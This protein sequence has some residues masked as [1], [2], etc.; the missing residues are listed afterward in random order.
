MNGPYTLGAL[1]D[2]C[3]LSVPAYQR[4][5]AWDEAQLTNF[6][7]DLR[8]HPETQPSKKYFFGTILLA[9][10]AE[11][12]SSELASYD[13]VDGQQ[14]LTTTCLFVSAAI[15][16]L[17]R[18]NGK[19]SLPSAVYED[20][21]LRSN[22]TRKFCTITEDD[23][24]FER[25]IASKE[26][27]ECSTPSQRRLLSA[28]QYF[29]R[30]LAESSAAQ[31]NTLLEKLN[32]AFILVYSVATNAEATQIFELQND[33]GKRLTNLEA[34]KSYLMHGIYV[35]AGASA[36]T[37][38]RIVQT[39]FAGIYRDIEKMEAQLDAPDEDRLLSYH[40]LAYETWVTLPGEVEGWRKPKELIKRLLEHVRFEERASWI[41]E[42]TY[43]L[44]QSYV[45]AVQILESRNRRC[46]IALGDLHV[47]GRTA[48][49]WPLFL[50]CWKFD[51]S[52]EKVQFAASVR[53]M[54]KFACR[55]IV[56]GKRSDAGES[57]LRQQARNFKGD[58]QSL[59]AALN[60]LRSWWEI[61]EM[62]KLKLNS[63]TFY[64]F[65]RVATYI[66]WRYEN[67]LREQ[68]GRQTGRL[69]WDTVAHPA[70]QAV[71]YAK[72]HIEPQ[73]PKNPNLKQLVKWSET[74]V[75]PRPFSEIYLNRLGNLVLDTVSTGASKGNA[76]FTRRIPKYTA[77]SVFLSQG[78]IVTRF[79]SIGENNER[80]WD[81][82]A[83]KR[84]HLALIEFATT[85]L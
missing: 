46:G 56:A 51:A 43:R 62:F 52:P 74:D 23:P 42:F 22:H 30:R 54:E 79:A 9:G 16:I 5:Y 60:N 80:I 48:P 6:F 72:D 50:K 83:I 61:P 29:L 19:T 58:F 37:D 82:A 53:H 78:E 24:F 17:G 64:E 40:C 26:L 21:Y 66:L 31:I 2:A 36:E 59:D 47:L 18:I 28:K 57:E 44:R 69:S 34:L 8:Q 13:I 25:L 20:R 71:K 41:K 63:P 45:H 35:H 10:S 33:R 32:D 75:E 77:E 39:D 27:P 81:E 1:F 55:S 85:H 49:F 38:L 4:A 70:N 11:S 15:D 14:R 7:D 3:T 65:G 67:Y 76:D 12:E 68:P 73:D 84:R